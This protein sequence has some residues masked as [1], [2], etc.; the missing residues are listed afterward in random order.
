M[1]SIHASAKE[2]TTRLCKRSNSVRFSIHASAKEA[3]PSKYTVRSTLN[4]FNPRL[5]EG[6]DTEP[7]LHMRKSMKIFNPRLREGGDIILLLQFRAGFF[8]NPRLREGGD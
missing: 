5:R 3:T 7:L 2:A 8:F 4:V 6:G 1:F